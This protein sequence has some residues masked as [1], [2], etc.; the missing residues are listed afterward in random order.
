MT[1]RGRDCTRLRKLT[2][3]ISNYFSCPVFVLFE[4]GYDFC[5][6]TG[7]LPQ[8]KDNYSGVNFTHCCDLCART[9]TLENLAPLFANCS[10][11][12]RYCWGCLT[13]TWVERSA[14]LTS[15]WDMSFGCPSPNCTGTVP[16]WA[17][18]K[19]I[20]EKAFQRYAP[21]LLNPSNVR[22]ESIMATRSLEGRPNFRRC[23]RATCQAGQLHNIP[24]IFIHMFLTDF[25]T[26]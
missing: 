20:G 3:R 9:V 21:V 8:K 2:Q 17:I 4:R 15:E 16:M 6:A 1:Y 19:C 24:C 10:Q 11:H 25:S 22:V 14:Q 23:P 7:P 12:G 26:G 5:L 13:K 18:R